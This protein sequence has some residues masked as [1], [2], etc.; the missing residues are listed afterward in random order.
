[1]ED[2]IPFDLEL[3]NEMVIDTCVENYSGAVLKALA[4]S[5]PKRRPRGD[6]RPS[7]TAVIQDKI[8]LKNR[9]RRQ[10]QIKRD[11]ALKGEENRLQKSVEE[12]PEDWDTRIPLS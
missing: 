11:L 10:W 1:M 4:A 7:I 9:L 3:H 6:T 2:L 8:S 5:T 12:R